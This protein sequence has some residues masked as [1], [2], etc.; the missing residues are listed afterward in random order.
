M[1]FVKNIRIIFFLFDLTR[2]Q[3]TYI[4]EMIFNDRW[5]VFSLREPIVH[6]NENTDRHIICV[7]ESRKYLSQRISGWYN[8]AVLAQ[9][10]ESCSWSST[11]SIFV[12][13]TT[14]RSS[15]SD[16]RRRCDY[17]SSFCRARLSKHHQSCSVLFV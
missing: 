6:W 10:I 7:V 8:W 2:Y 17:D 11:A 13:W 5:N 16:N 9:I 15:S 3:D 12:H 14:P 4:V 1:G